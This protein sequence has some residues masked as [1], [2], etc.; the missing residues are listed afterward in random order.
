MLKLYKPNSKCG[1]K[2]STKAIASSG[3]PKYTAYPRALLCG[4]QY[5]IGLNL[6]AFIKTEAVAGQQVSPTMPPTGLVIFVK[7]LSTYRLAPVN[8]M[9]AS[10]HIISDAV[11]ALHASPQFL[12]IVGRQLSMTSVSIKDILCLHLGHLAILTFSANI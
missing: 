9:N 8:E 10:N 2:E 11:V 1:S 7:W 5:R 3:K 12:Q 6:V 4:S